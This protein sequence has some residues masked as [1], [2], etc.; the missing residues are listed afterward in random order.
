MKYVIIGASAA[1][2]QAAED[3]RNLDPE[4]D[5]RLISEESGPPY[6]RC[7]ISRYADGRLTEDK[8][9]F[10]TAHFAEDLGLRHDAGIR[11]V[12]IDRD[13]RTVSCDNGERVAYDRILLAMGSRPWVPRIP[14]LDRAGVHTFHSLEDAKRVAV[15]AEMAREAV[16][17]GAGFVGLEAA[18]ALARRRLAV[19]VIERCGQILPNQFDSRGAA[20]IRDDLESLG[21]RIV[22]D[23]S[24]SA[25]DG[26]GRATGVTVADKPHVRADLVVIATGVEPNR[27]LAAQAGLET[28][29]GIRVNDFLQ[30]SDPD[31]FAAG[32]AIEIA[33]IS[34][35]RQVPSAT[36][37]NA[38]L[39]GRYA[40]QNMAGKGRRYL[41]SVGIQNAVQFHQIPAISFGQTLV[42]SDNHDD[43][44]VI[45]TTEGQSVYK[46]L[47]LKGN[48]I[49]GMIFVGDIQKSGFYSALIRHQVDV[50]RYRAKLLDGDFSY[51]A[52]HDTEQFGQATPFI[53]EVSC[54]P[55]V[56]FGPDAATGG[57]RCA[58]SG[59]ASHVLGW[60]GSGGA[61]G[62]HGQQKST[63][64]HE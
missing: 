18:Y 60:R 9:L 25:I 3:L 48:R 8:L 41:G 58:G 34:T 12:A 62:E 24:V 43:Y 33:D 27:D 52:F 23:Q 28:A 32:D 56:K 2:V 44:E 39:Q 15:A 47:V 14:G 53:P 36:W 57:G 42:D 22:L 30:T 63:S 35:G 40:G 29:R 55:D 50:S 49:V 61:E 59:P 5:I 13:A 4:G 16:V 46:K 1:G 10:K 7:L 54:P 51:A 17:I 38:V 64:F 11:V 20:I 45:S 19:T 6:S 26:N 37:F 21:V 31:I